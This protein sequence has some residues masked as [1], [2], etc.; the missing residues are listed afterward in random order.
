MASPLLVLTDFSPAA[1]HA[2]TYA[3]ALAE[4]LDTSIVL[5]HVRRTSLLDPDLLTGRIAH[6]SEGE[7]ATALAERT[8]HLSVPAIVEVTTDLVPQAITEATERLHPSLLIVGKPDTEY[9][10]DELVTTTS[11]EL[12]HAASC[13]MLV[14]PVTSAVASPPA[15]IT[16]AVDGKGFALSAESANIPHLLHELGAP[17][18]VVHIATPEE[19]ESAQLSLDS[20]QRSGL[21]ME[22]EQPQTQVVRHSDLAEGIQ[23]AVLLTQADLLVLVA[24]R[25]SLLGELFHHSVTAQVIRHSIVPVLVLPSED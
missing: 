12:I 18:T 5:L 17:L 6:L 4:K 2:L 13:P 21:T 11:L 25:H 9:T 23:E 24:R 20:V 8:N 22:L 14:V 10:P 7:V 19:T 16:L 15:H 3:N 1:D